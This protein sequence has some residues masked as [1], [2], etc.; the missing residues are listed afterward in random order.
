MAKCLICGTNIESFMSFGSM[1]IANGFLVKEQFKNEYFF[2]L[3]VASC[4]NC[5]MFQ[6]AEQPN[7]G[8]MFNEN[9]AFFSGTS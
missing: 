9:Y 2:E 8:K 7:R 1:P 3:K 4:S 6:L 5:G